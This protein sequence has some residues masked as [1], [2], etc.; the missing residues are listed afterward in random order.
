MKQLGAFTKKELLGHLRSGRLMM[1]GVLCCI[2]GIMNPATARL[3]PW[4]LEM[5]SEQLSESGMYVTEIEVDAL[6]S[7]AQFFKNTPVLLIVFIVMSSNILTAEYQKGTLVN[8][9]TKGMK[10]WKILISK[11]LVISGTWTAGYLI[12]FGIT[13]GYNAYFW[14]NSVAQNLLFAVFGYYLVGLWLL[15]AVL[16]ASVVLNSAPGVTLCVGA[17]FAASYLLGLLPALRE[18]VPT[19][20]LRSNEL[21]AGAIDFSQCLAAVGIALLLTALNTALAVLFFNHIPRC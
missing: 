16:P 7:W 14:D 3:M 13:Y 1:L 21:L 5:L 18:Y 19:F 2:L 20:A 9:I 15:S 11:L 12:T 10:R 6:A 17:A 4:L 8:V